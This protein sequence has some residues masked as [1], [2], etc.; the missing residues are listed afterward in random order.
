M[1]DSETMFHWKHCDF[2][3][4][5]KLLQPVVLASHMKPD[6]VPSQNRHMSK[7]GQKKKKIYLCFLFVI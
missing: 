7:S 6:D 5:P 1:S 3:N 4:K 2:F